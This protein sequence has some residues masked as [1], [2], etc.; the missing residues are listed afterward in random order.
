MSATK[1]A[2]PVKAPS[3]RTRISTLT[4]LLHDQRCHSHQSS[5]CGT[6]HVRLHRPTAT[7]VLRSDDPARTLHEDVCD[8]VLDRTFGACPEE[9]RHIA[10]LANWL[11][12]HEVLPAVVSTEA[13]R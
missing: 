13:M 5:P 7:K 2:P 10:F 8:A 4:T 11:S 9:D 6:T 12:K 1:T 3:E